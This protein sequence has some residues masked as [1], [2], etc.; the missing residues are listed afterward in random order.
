MLAQKP[1]HACPY[2]RYS[3]ARRR[4]SQDPA[5]QSPV[6]FGVHFGA[7]GRRAEAAIALR[8]YLHCAALQP[9][10]RAVRLICVG[11]SVGKSKIDLLIPSMEGCRCCASARM[12]LSV[13]PA[14]IESRPAKRV[15][16]KI[17]IMG[18]IRAYCTVRVT[19]WVCC[20]EPLAALTVSV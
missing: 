7:A 1:R 3:L 2:G 14:A 19:V 10:R 16:R 9:E 12:A 17:G 8:V 11:C 15:R 6:A 5:T 20:K 18:S 13:R 4:S